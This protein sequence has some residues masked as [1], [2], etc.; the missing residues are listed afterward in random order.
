M[1]LDVAPTKSVYESKKSLF[2]GDGENDGMCADD[3]RTGLS[4]CMDRHCHRDACRKI[5]A[6]NHVVEGGF[7]LRGNALRVAVNRSGCA[8]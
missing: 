7:S 6:D 8:W 3:G 5:G 4:S 1:V 2:I